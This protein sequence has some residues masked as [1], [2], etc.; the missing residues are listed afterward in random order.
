VKA[1]EKGVH[2]PL[3]NVSDIAIV[4]IIQQLTRAGMNEQAVNIERTYFYKRHYN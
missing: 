1:D 3:K 4:E 2:K